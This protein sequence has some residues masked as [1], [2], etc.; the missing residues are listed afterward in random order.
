MYK[1]RNEVERLF[2]RLSGIPGLGHC[3]SDCGTRLEA[4]TLFGQYLPFVTDRFQA[5]HRPGSSPIFLLLAVSWP[6]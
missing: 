2:R 6:Y 3:H 1:R 4:V 5:V